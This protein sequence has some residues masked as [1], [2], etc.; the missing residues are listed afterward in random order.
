MVS[1]V[2]VSPSASQW[3][4]PLQPSEA[5]IRPFHGNNSIQMQPIHGISKRSYQRHCDKPTAK[6]KSLDMPKWPGSFG[7]SW[8][9]PKQLVPGSWI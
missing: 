7:T 6:S 5:P 2:K 8:S 9:L 3:S 1:E 4:I